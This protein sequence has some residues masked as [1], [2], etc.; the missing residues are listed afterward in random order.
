MSLL[1]PPDLS[2]TVDRFSWSVTR[3]RYAASTTDSQG[4]RI[5]G[6]VTTAAI[7][8]HVTMPSGQQIQR[9]PE[10]IEPGDARIG[11]TSA[12]LRVADPDTG[13]RG[14]EVDVFGERFQV[15][16]I[17]P[18]RA[19]STGAASYI[20]ATLVRVRRDDPDPLPKEAT[21]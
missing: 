11:Y 7:T 4:Y 19:G 9:I 5:A 14:D 17:Q 12:D 6:S 13:A 18:Y 10:G 16:A 21:P 20:A 15:A 2:G 1:G 8:M 3:R